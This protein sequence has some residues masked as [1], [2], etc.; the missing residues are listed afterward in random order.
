MSGSKMFE[1]ESYDE[2]QGGWV[3][4]TRRTSEKDAD[5]DIDLLRMLGKRVRMVGSDEPE[6]R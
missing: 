2:D 1:V 3:I 4:E 6:T 5:L